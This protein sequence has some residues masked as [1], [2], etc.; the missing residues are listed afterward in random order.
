MSSHDGDL[1]N[2]LFFIAS[3]E[4][5]NHDD[6]FA[7]F[8]IFMGPLEDVNHGDNFEWFYEFFCGCFSFN[9]RLESQRQLV[10]IFSVRSAR[11]HKVEKSWKS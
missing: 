7:Y 3:S 10:R 2:F 6:N 11:L 1:L 8:L 9:V 4:D 5:D